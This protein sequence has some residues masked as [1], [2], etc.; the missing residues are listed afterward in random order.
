MKDKDN[1]LRWLDEI[2]NVIMIMGNSID[3]NMPIDPVDAKNRFNQV[4]DK[5]AKITDRVS[6]S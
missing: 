4:R 6:G 2:D 3:R 1:V 5:L